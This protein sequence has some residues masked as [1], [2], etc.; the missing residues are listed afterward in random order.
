MSTTFDFISQAELDDLDAGGRQFDPQSVF[1]LIGGA[2]AVAAVTAG[3]YVVLLEDEVT[4][5]VFEDLVKA[6]V[7]LRRAGKSDSEVVEAHT[8]SAVRRHLVDMLVTALGGG[9]RYD[10]DKLKGAHAHLGITAALYRR[11]CEHLKQV[12]GGAL[13]GLDTTTRMAI[14][15]AVDDKLRTLEAVIVSEGEAHA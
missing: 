5:P 1:L 12:L 13:A 14:I 2:R 4:A 6:D 11:V 7:E 8:L 10:V 9:N 15:C 3:F